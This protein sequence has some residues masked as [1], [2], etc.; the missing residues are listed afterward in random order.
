M[1]I[2]SVFPVS[3]LSRAQ[4]FLYMYSPDDVI[5]DYGLKYIDDTCIINSLYSSRELQN[6]NALQ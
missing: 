5:E 4:I 6:L 3:P 1:A 2:K